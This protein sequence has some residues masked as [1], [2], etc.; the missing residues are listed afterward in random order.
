MTNFEKIKNMSIDELAEKLNELSACEYCP[1]EEFCDKNKEAP[2]ADCKSIW[3][4]WLK[5]EAED[6]VI[7][8]WV[9]DGIPASEGYNVCV[10]SIEDAMK[11]LTTAYAASAPVE[12]SLDYDVDC[13]GEDYDGCIK[14]LDL[15]EKYS[16]Y[17]VTWDRFVKNKITFHLHTANPVGRDNMR[18]I[19]QKN[20]WREMQ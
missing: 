16:R 5:S 10:A 4:K 13:Q 7:K 2:R 14:I 8:I 3:G 19:I 9:G 1:I 18:R 15:L 6:H 12:I 20:G 17:R 11:E